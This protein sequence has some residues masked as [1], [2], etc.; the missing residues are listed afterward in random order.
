LLAENS[1]AESGAYFNFAILK[2][3][4]HIKYT[5]AVTVK[6]TDI[7]IEVYDG[8][9]DTNITCT[10]PE[11]VVNHSSVDLIPPTSSMFIYL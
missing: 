8:A 11:I 5:D 9:A 2:H 3:V 1:T 4:L 10:T 7:D 6:Q